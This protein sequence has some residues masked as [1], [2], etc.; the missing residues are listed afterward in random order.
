MA[1]EMREY[2]QDGKEHLPTLHYGEKETECWFNSNDY[3]NHQ[4]IEDG[5][6]VL[7]KK[8]QRETLTP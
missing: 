4:W 3:A 7:K 1:L 5:E 8:C 6:T 2:D